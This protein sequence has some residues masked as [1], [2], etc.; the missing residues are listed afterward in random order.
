MGLPI[1]DEKQLNE[2]LLLASNLERSL[3][4]CKIFLEIMLIIYFEL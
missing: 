4:F 1:Y 2:K 3:R